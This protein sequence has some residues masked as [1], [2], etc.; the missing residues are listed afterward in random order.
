MMPI[1]SALAVCSFVRTREL[2]VKTGETVQ[3]HCSCAL[4]LPFAIA[5]TELDTQQQSYPIYC[6][7]CV[8][9]CMVLH[10]T[11]IALEERFENAGN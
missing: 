3:Q 9:L 11:R 7:G 4:L 5:E 6:S 8:W 1:V 2:F 10:C